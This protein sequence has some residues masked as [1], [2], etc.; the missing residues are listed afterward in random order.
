M[1]MGLHE[2]GEEEE[3]F[4]EAQ[5]N[6]SRCH[7]T[8]A[9]Q[10]GAN[11]TSPERL[12]RHP[13][14]NRLRRHRCGIEESHMEAGAVGRSIRSACLCSCCRLV[15][16]GVPCVIS[17]PLRVTWQIFELRGGCSYGPKYQ[18]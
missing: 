12:R 1:G 13:S 4:A 16:A 7:A 10:R 3:V 2:L 8:C 18:L 5:E 17:F 15:F 11:P 9:N 14:L 6:G